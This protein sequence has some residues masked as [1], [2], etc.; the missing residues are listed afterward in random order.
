MADQTLA[1]ARPG[2]GQAPTARAR[3]DHLS[4]AQKAAIIVRVLVSEEVDF[5]LSSL[6][7]DRQAALTQAMGS[8]QLVDRA[9]MNAVVSEFV[10]LLEQVGLSF[11]DGIDGALSMLDGRLDVQAT[12]QL[13]ALARGGDG[14]DPWAELDLADTGDL[15]DL[16]QRESRVVGAV[17]LSKLT[18]AKAAAVLGALPGDQARAL[19]LAVARTDAIAPQ[20]VARIGAALAEQLREKPARAF[21]DPSSRRV[22]EILNVT[23]ARLRDSLLDQLAQA[24][25]DFASGVR[26]AIF[27]FQDI[28]EKIAPR[29]V[30]ALMR[31]LAPEDLALIMAADDAASRATLDFLLGNMSKRMAEGLRDDADAV[32]PPAPSALDAAQARVTTA[33][34]EMIDA[35]T[36]SL[37]L[38]DAD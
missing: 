2:T 23:P 15:C 36:I 19:A 16:L 35:G 1:R 4:G 22:G 26:D 34:R 5:P 18:T 24:D 28:P 27:T 29:D 38:P 11:P 10:D 32:E 20:A 17:V 25:A 9:T 31:A 33:I 3:T 30:P 6:P 21:D 13:R 7:A 12:R 14:H 8:L 37:R